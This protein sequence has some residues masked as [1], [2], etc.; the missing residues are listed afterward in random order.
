[1]Q[2]TIESVRATIAI[3]TRQ[4][5]S[6]ARIQLSPASLGS[7]QIQLQRTDEGL[8]A[9][10]VADRPETAQVLQQ[11]SGELRRSLEASGQ[12]LLRLDIETAGQRELPARHPGQQ[13]LGTEAEQ[14]EHET[15]LGDETATALG[16]V[17]LPGA[18]VNVLA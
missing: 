16:A 13:V 18:L 10:V 14:D 15:A 5:A 17:Q 4:G 9:R 8:V 11:S 7:I 12:P 6:Q 3:A 2:G 1:M